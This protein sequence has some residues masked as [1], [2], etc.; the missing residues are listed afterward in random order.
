MSEIDGSQGGNYPNRENNKTFQIGNIKQ[1]RNPPSKLSSY[2]NL[3]KFRIIGEPNRRNSNFTHNSGNRHRKFSETETLDYSSSKDQKNRDD[4]LIKL[5]RCIEDSSLE[6]FSEILSNQEIKW[7]LE[8]NVLDYDLF[9][10]AIKFGRNEFIQEMQKLGYVLDTNLLLIESYEEYLKKNNSE[11]EKEKEKFA[12]FNYEIKEPLTPE[13]YEFLITKCYGIEP[14][15]CMVEFYFLLMADLFEA[16]TT[17][18]EMPYA[19]DI[20]V[21]LNEKFIGDENN[22]LEQLL[23]DPEIAK[24]VICASLTRGLDGIAYSIYK[25]S[26]IILDENIIECAVEGDC[27]IFLADIWEISKKFYGINDN[28]SMK[29]GFYKYLT[30]MLEKGKYK[31]ASEAIKTWHEAYKEE[32]IFELLIKH[33]EGLAM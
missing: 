2:K 9:Y 25:F 14:E 1:W 22:F 18:L 11:S 28:Y 16:A 23:K 26:R 19:E 15:T 17:L 3:S 4:D 8:H 13:N 10:H 32:N 5:K 7:Y 30:I 6:T 33:S 21:I 29:I 31:M 12:S 27:T 20:K 24:D